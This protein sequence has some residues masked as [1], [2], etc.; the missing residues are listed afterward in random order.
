MPTNPD[1]VYRDEAD[2]IKGAMTRISNAMGAGHCIASYNNTLA[3]FWNDPHCDHVAATTKIKEY[4][5]ALHKELVAAHQELDAIASALAARGRVREGHVR[6]PDGMEVKVL[7]TLPM[8][9]DVC[10]VGDGVELHHPDCG[11]SSMPTQIEAY[12]EEH[13]MTGEGD[14]VGGCEPIGIL[15]STREAAQ[16]PHP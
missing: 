2:G 4:R 16:L 14:V 8:T 11:P 12:F 6:L 15:Y 3:R 5:D 13:H 9:A 10:I 1:Q 7:G